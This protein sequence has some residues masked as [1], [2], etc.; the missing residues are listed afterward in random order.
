MSEFSSDLQRAKSKFKQARRVVIFSGAGLSSESGIPTFRGADGLWKNFSAMDLATPEAFENDP[1]L[2]WEWYQWRRDL[3]A[4]CEPNPAHFAISAYTAARPSTAIVTQ[5]VD[6]LLERAG[7]K[8]V[9]ELHGNLWQ[10]RCTQCNLRREFRG[11]AFPELPH[12]PECKGLER[13]H[14]VW[15]GERLDTNVWGRAMSACNKADAILTVGTSGVVFPAAGLID[16]A[17]NAGAYVCG[18]N[19]EVPPQ[20][21][22]M[23]DFFMGKAGDWVPQILL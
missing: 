14:I 10:V 11:Q 9:V 17:R 7:V 20:I 19:L 5:N 1:E 8:D 18:V 22:Q 3:V 15:F 6:G 23:D 21:G 4:K 2:V 16:M 12:C 13:P